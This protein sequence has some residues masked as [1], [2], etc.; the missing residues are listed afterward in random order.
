MKSMYHLL[1]GL[2]CCIQMLLLYLAKKGLSITTF[3]T[4][5]LILSLCTPKNVNNGLIPK[6]YILLNL[7]A[8]EMPELLLSLNLLKSWTLHILYG[9]SHWQL[10]ILGPS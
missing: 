6:N 1:V 10:R 5:T 4:V 9:I 7:I 2:A 3:S 8:I